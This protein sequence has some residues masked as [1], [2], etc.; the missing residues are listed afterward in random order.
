MSGKLKLL[1]GDKC[2]LLC[3]GLLSIINSQDGYIAIEALSDGEALIESARRYK[4]DII[5]ANYCLPKISGLEVC[6]TL[7]NDSY[8]CRFLFL[9]DNAEEVNPEK[10]IKAGG[11]GVICKDIPIALLLF[12]L[13]NIAEGNKY[14]F[15]DR[16]NDRDDSIMNH[17]DLSLLTCQERKIL[18]LVK[19]GF[20][21]KDIADN[22]NISIRTV[23]KHRANISKKLSCSSNFN[24]S[25]KRSKPG[26]EYLF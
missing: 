25:K 26:K 20:K 16:D 15:P 8:K 21:N 18:N 19:S 11:Y 24:Y 4:P 5:I 14:F 23:E 6:Y 7:K 10:C 3:D 13:K 2:R 17:Q 9:S 22:C 12:A 1:I